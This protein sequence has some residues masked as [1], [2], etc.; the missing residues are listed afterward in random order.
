M[1]TMIYTIVESALVNGEMDT[2]LK[3]ITN[4]HFMQGKYG[5]PKKKMMNNIY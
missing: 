3:M 2:V 5:R 4:S 1:Q